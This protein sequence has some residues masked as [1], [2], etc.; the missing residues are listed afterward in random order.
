MSISQVLFFFI[1]LPFVYMFLL[2]FLISFVGNTIRQIKQAEYKA[3][4]DYDHERAKIDQEAFE[5]Y[6]ASYALAE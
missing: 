5:K 1:V 2:I 3:K 4:L 6:K